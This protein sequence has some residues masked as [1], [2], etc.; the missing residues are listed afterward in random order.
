MNNIKILHW[1]INGVKNKF[2]S[3]EVKR[4]INDID[5][6]AIQETHFNIRHKCPDNFYMIG[7]S[8]T[9][10]S[11][12][13]RGGVAVYRS[14]KCQVRL[15]AIK[16]DF[17]DCVLVEICNSNII[18]AAIYIPPNNSE[19]YNE[20]YFRN[21]QSFLDSYSMYRDI[22]IIGDMN[23]RTADTIIHKHYRHNNNPD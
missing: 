4:I 12:K 7:R 3:E 14:F 2:L 1:N 17:P 11:Y 16:S 9:V 13:P 19:Y 18:I 21:L 8:K 23:A 15:R 5:I 10:K 6:L 22:L 20:N